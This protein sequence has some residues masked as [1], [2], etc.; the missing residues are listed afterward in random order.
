MR[1][2]PKKQILKEGFTVK[3][4]VDAYNR[5][6]KGEELFAGDRKKFF[7]RLVAVDY[8]YEMIVAGKS[9]DEIKAMWKDDVEK[10]K[11]LRRKYLLYEE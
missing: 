6:G 11:V 1:K 4:V 3:Y 9:A 5:Y 2:V 8:I 10:F 7:H